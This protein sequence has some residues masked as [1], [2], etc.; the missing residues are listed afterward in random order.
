MASRNAAKASTA[1]AKLIAQTPGAWVEVL[2]LDLASLESVRAFAAAYAARDWPPLRALVCNAGVQVVSGIT[3]TWDGFESM[4]G[5][6]HLGHFRLTLL[7]LK[8]LA[9]P[10]RIVMVS[11]DTHDPAR[12]TR[13][14][15]PHYTQAAAL[16]WPEKDPAA[17]TSAESPATMGGR[18]YTTSKLCNIYFTYEL[19]R[20]LQKE[21][22][23]TAEKP[24]T[25]NAFNPGL[26]PGT[27]LARDY[28]PLLRLGWH[29]LL[30]LVRPLARRF[31]PINTV[32][33]SGQALARLVTDPALEAVSGKYFSGMD[34][35]RSS[36]ASYDP[37]PA[38]DLWETSLKLVK[39]AQAETPLAI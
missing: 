29:F 33:A 23:S 6:N 4:F 36:E 12:H 30:P 1:A 20:R 2:P 28:P 22:L 18:R 3:Y 38:L 16:A 7:L 10:A 27:G 9:A 8:H 37:Q 15:E 26:M 13:M 17:A 21:G 19:A 25:V 31:I 24:I 39:L 5:V 34:E 11:S 35:V 14:S 32:E